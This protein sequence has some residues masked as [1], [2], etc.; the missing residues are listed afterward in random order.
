MTK[1]ND[2]QKHRFSRREFLGTGAVAGAAT[3]L[4]GA[5][6]AE[7]QESGTAAASAS[8]SPPSPETMA[9]EVGAAMPPANVEPAVKRPAS[10]LMVQVL[11]DLEIEFVVGNTGSTFEGIQES[12]IN[13]GDT[14]NVMPE[15]ITALHEESA[16]DMCQGYARSEGKPICAAV[17]GAIGMQH[18]AMA[19]YQAFLGEAPVIILVGREDLGP[20]QSQTA[21]DIAG[22]VR[23]YTKWDAQP[24]TVEESL[25]ALQEA[26]RQA[27]TPP[28][29]PVVV[30]L[31][32]E[33]QK[34]EAGDLQVPAFKPATIPT[35]SKADAERIAAG[36]VAADNP[37]LNVG[38]FRTPVGIERAIELAEL[39]GA[40]VESRATSG[41]MSF[42]QT[43]PLSGPGG[44]EDYDYVLGLERPG[45]QASI[46]GPHL[47]TLDDRDI[48]GIGFGTIRDPKLKRRDTSGDFDKVA[49]A[50]NSLPLVIDA[51]REKLD[52]RARDSVSARTTKHRKVNRDTRL[53]ALREAAE[54][55]RAGWEASPIATARMYT[56]LYS[57]IKDHDWCLASGTIFSGFHNVALWDHDRPYSY[58]GMYPAAALGYVLGSSTGAAL[59]ARGRDRIVINIQGDGDFNYT[60]GSIWTAAHHNLPMLTIMHNNRAYHMEVMYLQ[61]VAGVR[62]RGTDR[63]HIGTTFRDP[64]IDYAKIAEGYGMKSEG[65]ISD[66]NELYAALERGVNT[67]LNGE[68]YLIDVITQPR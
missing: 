39:V 13:Y 68:P 5:A 38:R 61:H 58:L 53:A 64:Y 48:L 7:A 30:V 19:V 28:C 57:L 3:M 31:D 63:M 49:D 59:A 52:R 6:A 15:F 33:V 37:R 26:Y 46:Q 17:S 67:V 9:R 21:D 65:P 50:E 22:I 14:P 43:H 66:P 35:I 45:A 62:G 23:A 16:V 20:R 29:G 8:M 2:E 40:S 36:L 32:S 47:R 44:D 55:K 1:K 11:R 27:T 25:E 41:P 34:A 42:P 4:P 18:A 54:I 10:D 12:I 60:P 51:V 24:E 56:E